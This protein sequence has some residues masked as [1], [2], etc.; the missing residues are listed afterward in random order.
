MLKQSYNYM[1]PYFLKVPYP[2]FRSIKDT[3]DILAKDMPKA[4]DADPE[5]FYRQ[6]GR[7][8]KSKR[9]DISRASMAN[10]MKYRFISAD[11]HIDLR[12]LPKDLWTERLPAA[13]RERGPRVIE[14][15]KGAIL[16]LG[17]SDLQPA[18]L[19][20]RRAG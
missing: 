5:G 16:D 6:L 1:R 13:L 9:V 10:K 8:K 4:K 18:W 14:N 12:W 17:R 2:S 11:D 19:L 15:E 3:L 20:H 7:A